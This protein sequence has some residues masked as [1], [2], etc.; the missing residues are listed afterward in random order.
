MDAPRPSPGSPRL[1]LFPT[2]LERQR[3]DDQGAL[4]PGLALAAVCGFGPV[5][6]GA[7]T[8]QLVSELRPSRVILVGIAGAYDL[9][10]LPVGTAHVFGRVAIDGVGAGAGKDFLG[11]PALG[12]PQWPGSP[13]TT[14]APIPDELE[15]DVPAVA[16]ADASGGLLLT[17]CAASGSKPH[18]RERLERHASAIAEDMEAFAVALACALHG[19]PCT[20]VRGISNEVGDR[21]AARWRIPA[22]L[23][24][25]RRTLLDMF[26]A[27]L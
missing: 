11:P 15:L 1:L 3:F 13:Q 8:A 19:V 21:E 2:A 12:F 27:G 18:A 6:A 9:T 22:A 10:T 26:D 7:R 14:H 16:P 24:A 25:A 23:A 5:A 17:T 4:A 20:V